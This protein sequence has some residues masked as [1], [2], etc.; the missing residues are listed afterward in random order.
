MKEKLS[1]NVAQK[2]S[3][4]EVQAAKQLAKQQG[5]GSVF[6]AIPKSVVQKTKEGKVQKPKAT[7]VSSSDLSTS[8]S[9]FLMLQ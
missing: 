8:I 2:D 5:T 4:E 1:P 6:D 3:A 7:F 9:F